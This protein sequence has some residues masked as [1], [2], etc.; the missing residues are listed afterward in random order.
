MEG[1]AALVAEKH[2][3]LAL[4]TAGAAD[5]LRSTLARPPTDLERRLLEKWLEPARRLLGASAAHAAWLRGHSLVAE[6]TIAE[7][8]GALDS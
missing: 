7:L 5:A 1:L 4:R 8:V 3:D 2:P 6:A